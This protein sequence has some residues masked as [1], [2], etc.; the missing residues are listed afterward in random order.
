ML[1]CNKLASTAAPFAFVGGS[2]GLTVALDLADPS[3]P[4]SAKYTVSVFTFGDWGATT[5]FGSCC[6]S[7]AN[8]YNLNAQETVATLMDIEAGSCGVPVQAILGHGDSLYWT[9]I[10]SLESCDE[11][12]DASCEAKYDGDNIKNIPWVNAMGN[13]DYGGSNCICSVG[14]ALV[15][16]NTTEELFQGLENKLKWQAEYTSPNGDRWNMNDHFYIH[17]IEDTNSG[18]SIDIF[19]VDTNDA[20]IHGPT[21]SSNATVTLAVAPL[22]AA[23]LSAKTPSAVVVT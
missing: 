1:S 2:S 8:N 10:N 19:N 16:C 6:G 11:R 20:D 22:T 18:V 7:N 15:K 13:H 9:G 21:S 4:A 14:N 12:F 17:R 3:D 23:T 5:Y